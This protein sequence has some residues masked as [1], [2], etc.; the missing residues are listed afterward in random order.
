MT[1]QQIEMARQVLASRQNE[2]QSEI[3]Q[4]DCQDKAW[5]AGYAKKEVNRNERAQ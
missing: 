5:C 4:R 2:S 3:D 1:S